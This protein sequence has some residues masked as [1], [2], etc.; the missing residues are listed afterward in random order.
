M[1]H[2]GVLSVDLA[3]ETL[4]AFALSLCGSGRRARGS[5]RQSGP[6][7]GGRATAHP[8]RTVHR[9]PPVCGRCPSCSR[10]GRRPAST[11]RGR[12]APSGSAAPFARTPASA[13]RRIGVREASTEIGN[14]PARTRRSSWRTTESVPCAPVEPAGQPREVGGSWGTWNPTRIGAEQALDDLPPRRQLHEQLLRRKRD[15]QEEAD[16]HVGAQLSQRHL[17]DELKLVASCT[18]TVA[19]GAAAAAAL[20]GVA[21]VDR[22]VGLP[23]RPVEGGRADRVVI[24]GPERAVG[25]A[26]VE[27]LVVPP[28]SVG[29]PAAL[30]SP[31]SCRGR[32]R[33]RCFPDHPIQIPERSRSAGGSGGDRGRE[34]RVPAHIV[35]RLDHV[36][37]EP[38]GDN[39]EVARRIGH[40]SCHYPSAAGSNR[41][42]EK[43]IRRDTTAYKPVVCARDCR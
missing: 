1:A 5:E 41:P 22:S 4:D 2:V 3:D 25:V 12:R 13:A 10:G 37:R 8:L 17:R 42:A 33:R 16:A 19:P 24:K 32:S 14:A 38:V 21:A 31:R 23:P 15:V 9:R 29:W 40:L 26:D 43:V 20:L 27:V 7:R 36:H 11:P 28:R 34:A 35:L 18:H 39:Y 30:R 6:S